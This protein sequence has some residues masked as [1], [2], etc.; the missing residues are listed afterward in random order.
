[1]IALRVFNVVC[2]DICECEIV[3]WAEIRT[4]TSKMYGCQGVR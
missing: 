2:L 3:G 4:M 1:M